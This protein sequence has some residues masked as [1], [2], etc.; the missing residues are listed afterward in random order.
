MKF[1][2]GKAQYRIKKMP[3]FT[4]AIE[5]TKSELKQ[6]IYN[7]FETGID[8]T[9]DRRDMQTLISERQNEIGY[10]NAAEVEIEELS[11]Q[12]QSMLEE[13]EKAESTIEEVKAAAVAAVQEALKNK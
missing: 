4:S 2:V 9:I 5:Q 1:R 7:I 10:V 12:E 8:K 3:S 6:S 13:S 11:A